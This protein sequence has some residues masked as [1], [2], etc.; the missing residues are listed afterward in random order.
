MRQEILNKMKQTANYIFCHPEVADLRPE[1]T[2][3]TTALWRNFS[4]ERDLMFT[5]E[6][7]DSIRRFWR[8]GEKESR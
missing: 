7:G 3:S 4:R 6:Q 2:P 5:G 1:N 8:N